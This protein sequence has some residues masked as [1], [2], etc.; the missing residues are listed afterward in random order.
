[1]YWIIMPYQHNGKLVVVEDS[2]GEPWAGAR[3]IKQINLSGYHFINLLHLLRAICL[4][5]LAAAFSTHAQPHHPMSLS[6][7]QVCALLTELLTSSANC[8]WQLIVNWCQTSC[9]NSTGNY[10]TWWIDSSRKIKLPTVGI[11]SLNFQSDIFSVA[12]MAR[13]VK[14][15]QLGSES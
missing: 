10:H 13:R 2:Q 1:M 8:S 7:L 12:L 15:H 14:F 4:P 6:M 3:S 9:E 11:I 5:Y